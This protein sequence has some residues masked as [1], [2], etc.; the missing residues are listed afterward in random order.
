[1]EN[2]FKAQKNFCQY[3]DNINFQN[4]NDCYSLSNIQNNNNKCFT[5]NN[6]NFYENFFQIIYQNGNLF[7]D[8]ENKNRDIEKNFIDKIRIISLEEDYFDAITLSKDILLKCEEIQ[9]YLDFFS[10]GKYFQDCLL[11][12]KENNLYNFVL[13]NWIHNNQN[14][15]LFHLIIGYIELQIILNYEYFYYSNKLYEY[16]Y[17]KKIIDLYE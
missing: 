12:I 5:P 4:L 6:L 15:T 2:L 8:K 10:E 9:F 13:P 11:P 16:S 1:M 3:S 17:I 7:N 14:L